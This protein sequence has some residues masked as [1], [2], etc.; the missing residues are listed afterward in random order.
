MEQIYFY[1]LLSGVLTLLLWTPYIAARMVIW[2]I[3]TF[4]SNYPEDF[5]RQEPEVPLWVAR[6]HRAHLN[7]VETLPAFIAVAVASAALVTPPAYDD[8]AKMAGLFFYARIAHALVYIL[9]IPYLR[10]PAY[11]VSWGSI[12]AMVWFVVR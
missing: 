2:G 10:T 3:P 9:G 1:L 6:A 11:L 4:L 12:L 5:P 7:M 8:I